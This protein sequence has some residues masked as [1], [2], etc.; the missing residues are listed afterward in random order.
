MLYRFP[1]AFRKSS[2]AYEVGLSS[3]SA[4]KNSSTLLG[5][6]TNG[7]QQ[8]NAAKEAMAAMK[9]VRQEESEERDIELHLE[10][11]QSESAWR[12]TK[13]LAGFRRSPSPHR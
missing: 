4:R 9:E 5:N 1:L 11:A 13:S 7:L 3:K 10:I 12:T 8:D 6:Q 2:V